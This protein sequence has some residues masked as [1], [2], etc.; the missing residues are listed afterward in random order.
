EGNNNDENV[1]E[2][3]QPHPKLK[4]LKIEEF[5]G[6]KF[7]SWLLGSDNIGG[8]SL[9]FHHLLDIHLSYCNK[10]EK[11]PTLGHLPNLKVL[12]IQGMDNVRCI[13]T[14]FYSSYNGEGSSNSRGGSGRT[15]LFPALEKLDLISM[16]NLVEW[17][18]VTEPTAEIGVIF[19]RLEYLEIQAC[20]KLTSAPHHFPSL[21][22]LFINRI[23]GPAFEKIISELTT[24]TSLKIWSISELACLPEH[25]LQKNRSLKNLRIKYCPDLKSILPHGHVWPICTSLRSL[26]ID[27]C[28]KLSTLPDALHNLN[29]LEGIN[30]YENDL[31]ELSSLTK[32]AIYN[33]QKLR[34]LPDGLDFLTRLKHLEIGEFCQELDSFPSLNSI[35]HS[36]EQLHLYGWASLNSLPKEIQCFTAL[37]TLQISGFGEMNALP[38][39]LGNLSSLQLIYIE[40]CEK[41]MYLPKMQAMRCLIKLEQLNIDNCPK[42]EERCAEGSGAEWSKIAHIPGF[43]TNVGLSYR[44]FILKV[45]S[46]EMAYL[47]CSTP[48]KRKVHNSHKFGNDVAAGMVGTRFLTGRIEIYLCENSFRAI[49]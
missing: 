29:F 30:I 21:K 38:E 12:E 17:N 37:Q 11:I 22:E 4:S 49:L 15:V 31:K 25:F 33:C 16:N 20:K 3:L 14:E 42:L 28:D 48:G 41:L 43:Q 46:V 6:E 2:G 47:L 13:G 23:R 8:G 1:L 10:C 36:L 35:Q 5:N 9:L 32:L 19:P 44:F 39:W 26:D 45:I 40:N 27:G 34:C 18:G 24:L 7:P